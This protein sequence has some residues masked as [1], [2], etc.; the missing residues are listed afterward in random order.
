MSDPPSLSPAD[1]DLVRRDSRLPGL[2]TLLA[3]S[4][5]LERLRAQRVPVGLA[6]RPAYLRYKPGTSCLA[7]YA[8]D[9]NG[10]ETLAHAVAY[11]PD[12]ADKLAKAR[13]RADRPW[14]N[15]AGDLVLNDL[16]VAVSIFPSDPELRPL[17]RLVDA[18]RRRYLLTRS[19]PDRPELADCG[20]RTLRYK[21]RRRFV[22]VLEGASGSLAVVR[23]HASG[24]GLPAEAT[25]ELCSRGPLKLPA[26]LGETQGVQLVE[27]LPGDVLDAESLL[28]DRQM[29]GRVG[30]ALA[31]LHAQQV[32]R[33]P[34]RL[35]GDEI[36]ALR[37]MA[38]AMGLV[39]PAHASRWQSSID[40][41]CDR[42]SAAPLRPRP[43]HGDLHAEQILFDG[44]ST[45]LIDLDEARLGDPAAD[46]GSLMAALTGADPALAERVLDELLRGYRHEGGRLERDSVELHWSC[47]LVR[48]A[49]EPFRSRQQDW[50]ERVE[51]RLQ[52]A[53]AIAARR[54]PV[55]G[56]APRVECLAQAL[57]ADPAF[58]FAAAALDPLRAAGPICA[59]LA[60]AR[61]AQS[62]ATPIGGS[63]RAV[64]V[65]RHK[66]GRRS[67]VEYEL[68]CGDLAA[69]ATSCTVLGK[70]RAKGLDLAAYDFARRLKNAG[71]TGQW[72]APFATPEP[73]GVVPEWN[74]WL[75]R[76]VPGRRI[77][78]LLADSIGPAVS[79]RVADAICGL[80]NLEIRPHRRHAL[81]DELAILAR[82]LEQL[83]GQRPDI[84]CRLADLLAGCRGLADG[85][86][87]P[88]PRPIH[89]D[90]Y[91]DQALFDGRRAWIV[92]LDLAS[93]GDPAV[94]AGNF[95]AH[96]IEQGLREQGD[97]A[98]FAPCARAFEDRFVEL[99]GEAIRPRVRAYTTLSLARHV[100]IGSQI[101]GREPW[102]ESIL[103]MC[104][105]RL[106]RPGRANR[107]TNPRMQRRE[108]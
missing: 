2:A 52:Q 42:L 18:G 39:V 19:V 54:R 95:V 1:S 60:A 63:V 31:H 55:L 13:L 7:G 5:L 48:S 36:A 102:I 40:R 83:A 32:T 76:K 35:R 28:G 100:S 24:A 12:A 107:S 34:T 106:R 101:A 78:D 50:P 81:A 57:R 68:H 30:A 38:M 103:K 62:G 82:R 72:D 105:H 87:E 15:G 17:A 53:E 74:A 94:D 45:G 27:W 33:L 9:L 91:P 3:P 88:P 84:A 23:C 80:H 46:V 79:C 89:R 69:G 56:A 75:Q 92:D 108:G 104:E 86:V 14:Q 44:E 43:I 71:Y 21:P 37:A 64:R 77:A 65:L 99:S 47:A 49:L 16:S 73:L 6:A 98:A 59:S 26:T 70:M 20:L 67:L 41:L 61:G 90:F 96:V 11:P 85:I 10:R 4:A 25:S 8:I 29:A 93:L 66:P 22:G 51:Q 97:P 58:P